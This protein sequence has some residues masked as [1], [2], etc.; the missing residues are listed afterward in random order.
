M[1][2]TEEELNRAETEQEGTYS[3]NAIMTEEEVDKEVDEL[4]LE[5]GTKFKDENEIYDIRTYIM[6][7]VRNG[8]NPTKDELEEKVKNEV[9]EFEKS[10]EDD[11]P[12]MEEEKTLENDAIDRMKRRLFRNQ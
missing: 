10:E 4:I 6:N 9:E 1:H 12:E 3:R 7:D 5:N 11:E 2:P 8:E